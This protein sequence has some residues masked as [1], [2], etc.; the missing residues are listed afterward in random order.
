MAKD[1]PEDKYDYKLKPEM[2][3]FGAVIVH[4]AS[5]NVYAAKAAKGGNVNWDDLDPKDYKAKAQVVSLIEKSMR[6]LDIT[7]SR[8]VGALP[9][10]GWA[11]VLR[12]T[13]GDQ[14]NGM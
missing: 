11:H 2:R 6:L 10:P 12:T 14:R 4:V 8:E 3:T 7:D 5:G 1:F 9:N 13:S